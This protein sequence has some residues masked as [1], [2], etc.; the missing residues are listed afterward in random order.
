[1]FDLI[2]TYELYILD[3][4]QEIMSLQLFDYI[5]M[6]FTYIGNYGALWIAI[7]LCL[8]V[9][10][11]TRTIGL[12]CMISLVI[13]LILTNG[14]LKNFFA[15]PRPFNY[16]DIQLLIRI[17]QDYSFPSGHTTSSFAVA[18]VLLKERLKLKRYNLYIPI[19]IIAIFVAFSRMYL[20]VHFLS[21]IIA[22]ILIGYLCSVLS[23]SIVQRLK[24]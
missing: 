17:P 8:L 21:D 11:K 23:I 7:S 16:S 22:G 2:I 19:I 4:M 18:F 20:Y 9:Y 1:M 10:P 15:R 5:W 24:I 12:M 13:G 6:F 3:K 14:I